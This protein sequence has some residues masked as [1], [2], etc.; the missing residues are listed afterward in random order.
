MLLEYAL[1]SEWILRGQ[2]F[3]PDIC[4]ERALEIAVFV[5]DDG[6]IP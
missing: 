3:I 4:V 1:A 6:F 5:I 2:C